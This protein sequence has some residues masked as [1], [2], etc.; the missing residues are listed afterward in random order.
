VP[1]AL[2]NRDILRLAASIP[3]Q[4]RLEGA[5]ARVEKRSPVCGSRVAVEV[6]L[7]D[8]GRI[9]A[10]GQEVKACALGQASAALM[11]GHAL[12]RSPDELAEARDA[13]GAYLAGT[14]ADPG[15]WPGLAVF[16]HARAHAARHASILL[17]FEA[18]A[19]AAAAARGR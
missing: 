18:A 4:G 9:A 19:E 10:L 16:A 6:A 5:Q 15:G 17:A 12:G 11:G 8:D 2:Y 3:H 14:R 7:D 1:S 13:L